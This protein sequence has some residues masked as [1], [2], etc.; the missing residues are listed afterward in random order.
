MD[1]FHQIM[2]ETQLFGKKLV[3]LTRNGGQLLLG[4]ATAVAHHTPPP[5]SNDCKVSE[6]EK[7]RIAR[8]W[9]L[10][11]DVME[12]NKYHQE[13]IGIIPLYIPRLSKSK[14]S[15]GINVVFL[16]SHDY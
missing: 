15:L 13:C 9:C 11:D 8:M 5:M 10:H 1:L 3:M 14:R 16:T 12:D 7:R 4:L 6:E 2:R